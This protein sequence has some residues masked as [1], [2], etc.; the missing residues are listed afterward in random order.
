MLD[1]NSVSS[2]TSSIPFDEQGKYSG[3]ITCNI[4]KN[5]QAHLISMAGERVS[6]ETF[7]G[8]YSEDFRRKFK[9]LAI[10]RPI[11]FF[12]PEFISLQKIFQNPENVKKY[13]TGQKTDKEIIK[14]LD[15]DSVR[16]LNGDVF[17]GFAIVDKYTEEVIG[18]AGV[19][20]GDEPGESQFGLILRSDHHG[21]KLG[22]ETIV[23]MAALALVYFENQYQVGTKEGKL[24][25]IHFRATALN[26]NHV[27]RKLLELGCKPI[28]TL[29]VGWFQ[30]FMHFIKLDRLLEYIGCPLNMRKLYEIKGSELRSTLSKHMDINKLTVNIAEV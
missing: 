27:S 13:A 17:T 1:I 3:A 6:L 5:E 25:V 7:T 8:P 18:R 24:P 29:P 23:L 9:A 14:G 10:E 12:R 30:R 15:R 22:K 4:V 16:P 2:L 19:G 21:K 11:T 28:K 20:R 26:N